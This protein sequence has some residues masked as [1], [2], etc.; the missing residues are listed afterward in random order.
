MQH[1][2]SVKLT[3]ALKLSNHSTT[4]YC[5]IKNLYPEIHFYYHLYLVILPTINMQN[6]HGQG[7]SHAS[8]ESAVPGKIQ[9]KAPQG[10]EE[11]LPDK[12]NHY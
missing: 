9:Q 5:S 3:I 2:N 6:E 7:V 4:S 10:L 11:A 8:G 12:V 1:I